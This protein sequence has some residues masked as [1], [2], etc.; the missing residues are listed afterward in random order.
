MVN[1]FAPLFHAHT[2]INIES[3]AKQHLQTVRINEKTNKI[4]ANLAHNSRN[5]KK[6]Y[7]QMN[8]IYKTWNNNNAVPSDDLL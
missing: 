3:D 2:Q 4:P 7:L 1:Q 5:E 6:E 8:E